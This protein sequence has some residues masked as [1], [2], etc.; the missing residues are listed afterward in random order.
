[1]NVNSTELRLKEVTDCF[2][3]YPS[4]PIQDDNFLTKPNAAYSWLD[5]HDALSSR[6]IS[7]QDW[8]LAPYLS[9]PILAFHHLFATSARHSYAPANN[10]GK[11][12]DDNDAKLP[13]SGPSA[14]FMVSEALKVN[15]AAITALQNAL[16]LPLARMYRSP[17]DISTELLPYIVRMLSPD[18]KP[19]V[20]NSSNTSSAS[21]AKTFATASVRKASEKAL[22]A[23]AAEC[24]AATG[25]RFEK[26]RIE[27]EGRGNNGGWVYRM[28]P[29]LDS[30][31]AFET[32]SGGDGASA[33]RYAV[34]QVLEMEWK[35]ESLRRGE[36]ARKRRMGGNP[37]DY[38]E[39]MGAKK[40][41]GPGKAADLRIKGAKKDFFGRVVKVIVPTL[42]ESESALPYGVVKRKT[43]AGRSA[44]AEEGRV[45]VSF[46]EG[47]SNAVRKPITLKEFMDGL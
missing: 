31:S 33:V 21:G 15:T 9:S 7:S 39:E 34:R 5:F 37:E 6:L 42:E 3:T 36:E 41:K 38:E 19:V 46:N 10:F 25:V 1:M 30:L 28:E 27:H 17:S 11:D 24:M 13:F 40:T 44:G 23:R 4:Q 43:K 26:T 47:F 35:K 20:I 2:T 16:S 45:W 18:V 22:V 32:M 14:P 12:D 8:E 29:S